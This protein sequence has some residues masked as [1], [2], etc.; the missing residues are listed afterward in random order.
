MTTDE[1]TDT[2]KYPV[3]F[4]NPVTKAR[5]LVDTADGVARVEQQL[6]DMWAREEAS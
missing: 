4:R 1:T 3:A 5:L 6:G 2:T